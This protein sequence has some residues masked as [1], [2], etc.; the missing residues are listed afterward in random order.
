VCAS[1]LQPRSLQQRWCCAAALGQLIRL[2]P[3][4]QKGPALP[5]RPARLRQE[6]EISGRTRHT[7]VWERQGRRMTGPR[8]VHGVPR[9]CQRSGSRAHGG[10]ARCSCGDQAQRRAQSSAWCAAAAAELTATAGCCGGPQAMLAAWQGAAEVPGEGHSGRTR[11]ARQ[12]ERAPRRHQR[13]ASRQPAGQQVQRASGGA[14]RSG[15]PAEHAAQRPASPQPAAPPLRSAVRALSLPSHPVLLLL[16][17]HPLS[18]CFC[19]CQLC[20]PV[21]SPSNRC[22]ARRV[23]SLSLP[24]LARLPDPR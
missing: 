18:L 23:H 8:G 6:E 20:E 3:D 13:R 19:T 15:R 5:H 7:A 2:T 11:A 9:R 12:A 22:T 10:L 4:T 24:S 14:R 16:S 17:P 1:E 21:S